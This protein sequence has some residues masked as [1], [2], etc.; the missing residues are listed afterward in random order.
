MII[1]KYFNIYHIHIKHRYIKCHLYRVFMV[2]C[3][4]TLHYIF[5]KWIKSKWKYDYLIIKL[6]KKIAIKTN[7]IRIIVYHSTHNVYKLMITLSTN[8]SVLTS[9]PTRHF[10]DFWISQLKLKENR[11]CTHGVHSA[12]RR[13]DKCKVYRVLY[14]LVYI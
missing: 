11:R 9:D 12:S 5:K 1:D 7:K 2:L 6:F 3:K 13:H 4:I 8:R 10:L 14:L